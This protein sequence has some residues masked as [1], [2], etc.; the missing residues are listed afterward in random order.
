[1][2][3]LL[4][5]ETAKGEVTLSFA[6]I[7]T[8]MESIGAANLVTLRDWVRELESQRES[9]KFERDSLVHVEGL[10]ARKSNFLPREV[11]GDNQTAALASSLQAFQSGMVNSR[12]T[13][14]ELVSRVTQESHKWLP[15]KLSPDSDAAERWILVSAENDEIEHHA[16]KKYD[17]EAEAWA[18][19]DAAGKGASK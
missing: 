12:E 9:E 3:Y 6:N 4:K 15:W 13:T 19:C 2:N 8:A 16:G 17:T 5:V 18:A 7:Q 10:E 11:Y 1:M 14:S